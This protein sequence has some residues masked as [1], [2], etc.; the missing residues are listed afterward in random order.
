MALSFTSVQ[1]AYEV[2][3][4]LELKDIHSWPPDFREVEDYEKENPEEEKTY[5]IDRKSDD[6]WEVLFF[7]KKNPSEEF[8]KK[9]NN[10][11]NTIPNSSFCRPWKNNP[12][13]HEFGW[14]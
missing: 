11:K 14:F 5:G 1:K 8:I 3:N 10:L 4:E 12:E 2:F 7:F 9:W 6:G 13:Y